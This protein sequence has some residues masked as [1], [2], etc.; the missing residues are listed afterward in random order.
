MTRRISWLAALALLAPAA[1]RAQPPGGEG[2][3][4]GPGKVERR[5][6]AEDVE[7]LRRLL[8]RALREWVEHAAQLSGKGFALSPDGRTLVTREGSGLRYWDTTTGRLLREVSSRPVQVPKFAPAEGVHLKG[9]GVV[10]TV[11]LP[12]TRHDVKAAPAKPS[13]KPLSDWDRV[14]NELHGVKLTS[15]AVPGSI[16][17]SLADTILR[18]LAKNGHHFTQLSPRETLTVVVTFREPGATDASGGPGPQQQGSPGYPAPGAMG[19]PSGLLNPPGMGQPPTTARD[20]ELLGDLHLKQGRAHDA[21]AAYKKA[22]ERLEAGGQAT[23]DRFSLRR[24]LAIAQLMIAERSSPAQREAAVKQAVAWLQGAQ[25][26]TQKGPAA[27]LPARLIISAPK[28]LLDQVGSGKLSFAE[29]R[30]A[31]TVELQPVATLDKG[32]TPKGS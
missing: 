19:N 2:P 10:Y 8:N 22:L 28:S 23:A 27:R 6:T 14:R 12:P 24:K 13:G 32:P 16:P 31:A 4:D 1:A 20:H 9:Q 29:F 21:I 17:P 30:R 18:L 26:E 11:T 7:I 25:P 5:Q 3:G 15:G